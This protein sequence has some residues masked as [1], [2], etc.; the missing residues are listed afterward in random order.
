MSAASPAFSDAM[1]T[2]TKS[3]MNL[4]SAAAATN[5]F[6]ISASSIFKRTFNWSALI[7]SVVLRKSKTSS[8][9]FA[10]NFGNNLSISSAEVPIK[11]I[12]FAT[13]LIIDCNNPL[14]IFISFNK[15]TFINSL[16]LCVSTIMFLL[17]IIHLFY[18]MD[19]VLA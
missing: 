2:L 16:I 4:S 17:F 19:L 7:S 14:G 9:V 18:Q 12:G 6:L 15:G 13:N 5:K 11:E 1:S 3:L 10:T 8:S